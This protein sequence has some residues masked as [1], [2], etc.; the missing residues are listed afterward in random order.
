[1]SLEIRN[2]FS[3]QDTLD[4]KLSILDI[5]ARDALGRLFNIEMQMLAPAAVRERF[6]YY[7]ADLYQEQLKKGDNYSLLRPTIS[8]IFLN[9]VVFPKPP[10][11]HLM[12]EIMNR[13][14]RIAFTDHF[15]LHTME[16]PKFGLSLDKLKTPLDRWC[17]FLKNAPSLDPSNLPKAMDKPSI[18][19]AIEE[20][21]MISQDELERERYKSRLK[22]QRDDAFFSEAIRAE[23]LAKGLAEG[24]TEGRTEG[25][26]K[27][28]I[29]G[30]IQTTQQMLR[31][32]ITSTEVLWT[33]T[34][35]ELGALADQLESE[36]PKS[37]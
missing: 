30:R 26:A 28:K 34:L 12:F 29:I 19:R 7:W 25:Q 22:K 36:L 37:K 33:Q 8:I 31:R 24:R 4:D 1:V 3:S 2:P 13:K 14:H 17:Y 32:E 20:L 35:E 16:L 18:R 10:D 21:A 5:K 23:A 9:E 27:A 11:Y 6:V 15:E